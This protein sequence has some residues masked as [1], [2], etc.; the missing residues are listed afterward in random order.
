MRRTL[1]FGTVLALSL[2][3]SSCAALRDLFR[4]AFQKPDLRFKTVN[5]KNASLSGI[6]LDTVWTLDNP[7]PVGLSLAE[8]DYKLFIEGK[9]VVAGSPR[10]GLTIP[11]DNRADLTFPAQL[12]FAELAPTL[13]VF[14]NQDTAKYRAEGHIG[15]KTPIGVIKFPLKKEGSF[16]VPKVPQVEFQ[17]PQVTHLSLSGATLSIPL[18]LTNRNS[19]PLPVAGITGQL[20]IGGANIGNINTGEVGLLAGRGTQTVNLPVTVNFSSALAAANAI[21][22]GKGQV[23]LSGN[24]VS[25]GATVPIVLSQL[26]DFKLPR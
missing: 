9:Q 18:K 21:R 12:K 6:N 20:A 10:R 22:Q 14:L 26:K 13:G 16:E 25:G 23:A 3:L 7:N 5:L 15:V 11:A 24:L 17:Q 4:T 2:S 8:L 19:F 1:L